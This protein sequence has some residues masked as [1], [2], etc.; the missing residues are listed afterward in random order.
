MT[1]VAS[2]ITGGTITSNKLQTTY[3]FI[4]RINCDFICVCVCEYYTLIKMNELEP[5]VSNTNFRNIITEQ[6]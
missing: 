4:N 3:M 6:K 5:H 2:Q 1:E